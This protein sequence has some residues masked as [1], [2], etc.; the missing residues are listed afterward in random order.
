MF[1]GIVL[2]M[3]QVLEV[4]RRGTGL[5]L[6]I[7][8]E[9]VME[10]LEIGA[11][12][13]VD[14]VCLTVKELGDKSFS[15]DVVGETIS[16]TTI[17]LLK[18]GDLVNLEP[19]LCVGDSIGGHFVTGHIDGVGYITSKWQD[20]DTYWMEINIGEMA[21]GLVMK[22]SVCIDGVSLTVA[23]LGEDS[24]RIALIPFTLQ[25]TTLGI[26]GVGAP[27]NVELDILGKYV[28]KALGSGETE[29]IT[30]EFLKEH[31]FI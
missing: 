2:E 11:S 15:V 25:N 14:G 30:E 18:V 12:I 26:K 29:G 19:S 21:K 6:T 3:G 22:G 1:T 17:G 24:V 28:R 10:N 16:R 13:A 4:T 7:G 8:A 20:G 9:K 27:V 31:G 5:H 23:G